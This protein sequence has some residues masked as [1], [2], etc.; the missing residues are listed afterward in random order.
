MRR[1]MCSDK[2]VLRSRDVYPGSKFFHPGSRIQG[3]KDSGSQIRIR[4]KEYDPGC[5]SLIAIPPDPYFDFLLIPDSGSRG[6]KAP[7][8]QHCDQV[9]Y[10]MVELV[11]HK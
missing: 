6:Q 1:F 7:D 4:I 2:A 11:P 10:C 5:S 9:Q 3:K 8:P